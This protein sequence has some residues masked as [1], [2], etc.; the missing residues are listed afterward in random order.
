MHTPTC[1]LRRPTASVCPH[2]PSVI[3][4]NTKY[5]KTAAYLPNVHAVGANRQRHIYSVVDEQGD[6]PRAA[7]LQHLGRLQ[8]METQQRA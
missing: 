6:A 8:G 5:H 1:L 3:G 4:S 2:T 7:H